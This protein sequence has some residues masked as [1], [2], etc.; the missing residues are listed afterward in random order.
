M[1][2]KLMSEEEKAHRRLQRKAD[3]K[4]AKTLAEVPLFADLEPKATA[5][6]EYWHQ[7]RTAA[8]W[9]KES[10][11]AG[12]AAAGMAGMEWLRFRAI[13]RFAATVIGPE[14]TAKIV[15]HIIRVYP[16]PD[17]GVGVFSEILTGRKVVF[18]FIRVENRQPGQPATLEGETFQRTVLTRE[19]LEERFGLTVRSDDRGHQ[20]DDG[21]LMARVQ[22]I[23][24]RNTRRTPC[25]PQ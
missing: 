17:Y 20:P 3:K 16:M 22:E 9:Y 12:F 18:N 24:A 23:I 1:A 4:N 13:E 19:Q 14:I 25:N 8:G 15:A 11:P 6:S 5:R 10:A 2:K 7:R 21:D